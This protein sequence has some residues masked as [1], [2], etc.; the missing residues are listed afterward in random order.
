MLRH[1]G[2]AMFIYGHSADENDKHIYQAIFASE[3][4]HVFF[5][6]YKPD[7][8]KLKQIDGL[9]AKYQKSA[10]SGTGYTFFDSESAKVWDD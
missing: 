6:V 10:G 1:N 7:E 4:K 5:G 2:A 9:L 3:A 8:D